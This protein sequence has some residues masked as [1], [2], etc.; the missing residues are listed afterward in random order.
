LATPIP[1]GLSSREG[2]KFGLTVGGAFLVL[3]ALL[4]WRGRWTAPVFAGLGSVLVLAGLLIPTRL[5]P[6]NR[7]W[8]K[9]A[10]M[11]S[12]V[13]TP[14]FMGVVYF[15][16]LAPIG[17]IMRTFGR[18][19]MVAPEKGQSFW[20]VRTPADGSHSMKRQF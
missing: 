3:G 17:F 2:R 19:P 10:H 15:L 6:V 14:I 20:A 7:A 13:T 4:W 1:A 9:L 8:M 11:I 12:R 18:N 16:V 5:G